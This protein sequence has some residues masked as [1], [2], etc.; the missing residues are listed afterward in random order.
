M[1]T[2]GFIGVRENKQSTIYGHY[3]HYDSYPAVLGCGIAEVIAEKSVEYITK[4]FKTKYFLVTGLASEEY[5]SQHKSFCEAL[6]CNRQIF[7]RDAGE[8]YKDGLFCEWSYIFNLK[9]ETISIYKGFGKV[10]EKGIEDWN[11]KGEAFVYTVGEFE[12]N[13]FTPEL[14]ERV[15]NFYKVKSNN[16]KP[17]K[18]ADESVRF[19]RFDY[20]NKAGEKSNRL[21]KVTNES[22]VTLVGVDLNKKGLRS[23]IKKNMKNVKEVSI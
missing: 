21:V 5:H 17:Y 3:N 18:A 7:I 20:E 4:W 23:F 19:V 10:A 13:T 1:G 12:Y 11:Y 8:F 6:D 16:G 14:M 2:R 22:V 9:E 15:E